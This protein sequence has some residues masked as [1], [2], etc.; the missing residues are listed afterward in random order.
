[1][2]PKK[3]TFTHDYI[4]TNTQRL[5]KTKYRLTNILESKYTHET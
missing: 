5:D 1:M 2:Q 3:Y 4:Y